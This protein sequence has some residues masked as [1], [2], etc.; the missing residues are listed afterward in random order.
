M[1][2]LLL[3][4]KVRD[5]AAPLVY[6]YSLRSGYAANGGSRPRHTPRA[7]TWGASLRARGAGAFLERVEVRDARNAPDTAEGVPKPQFPGG[8]V[9]RAEGAND[10]G[11]DAALG[12]WCGRLVKSGVELGLSRG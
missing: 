11:V 2:P 1:T 4:V 12:G 9:E 8:P 5:G 6:S 3:S 7:I 10:A